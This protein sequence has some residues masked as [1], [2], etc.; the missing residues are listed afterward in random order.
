M[1]FLFCFKM[2]IIAWQN[3]NL[4]MSSGIEKWVSEVLLLWTRSIAHLKVMKQNFTI[5]TRGKLTVGIFTIK[6]KIGAQGLDAFNFYHCQPL[7][8]NENSR[9]Q[10]LTVVKIGSFQSL[11]HPRNSQQ[12]FLISTLKNHINSLSGDDWCNFQFFNL[13]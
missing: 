2:S 5:M 8:A 6:C 13:K 4:Y 3:N 12:N 1:R 10:F 11:F 9:R 7:F